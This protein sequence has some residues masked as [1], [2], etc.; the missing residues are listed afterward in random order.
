VANVFVD[1]SAFIQKKTEA[2]RAHVTQ[3][4]LADYARAVEGLDSC[5]ASM[6]GHEGYAEA[7]FFQ[8][9][10]DLLRTFP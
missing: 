5:R 2:I 9:S 10:S 7:F 3:T 8:T 4:A 6:S 1:I